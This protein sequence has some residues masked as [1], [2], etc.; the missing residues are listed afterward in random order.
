MKI[1]VDIKGQTMEGD[2][3]TNGDT[4]TAQ[5]FI[6]H[7]DTVITAIA[8]GNH[9]AQSSQAKHHLFQAVH[10]SGNA[11]PRPTQVHYRIQ[12]QLSTAMIGDIPASF[13]M[14]QGDIP[15]SEESFGHHEVF[16]SAAPAEGKG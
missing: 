3:M 7:P 1:N 10:I 5:F 16:T 12:H 2:T 8:A 4:D 14:H 13:Y 6:P 9:P 11:L 15:F